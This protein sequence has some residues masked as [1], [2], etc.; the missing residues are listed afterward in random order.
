MTETEIIRRLFSEQDIVY[1]D[2][3]CRLLPG[4]E[5]ERVIGV[6]TPV[7]RQMAKELVM[8]GNTEEFLTRLPHRYFEENQLHSFI[9]SQTKNFPACIGQVEA[10]LPFI[11]NWATCDQLSPHCFR[12]HKQTLLPHIVSWLHS[13]KPY[14]IRF[15]MKMLMDYFLDDDFKSEFLQDVAAVHSEHYYVQMMQAWYF[16]TALAKQ[17][18]AAIPYIVQHRLDRWT[19]NKTIRKACESYRISDEK[20]VYL[21]TLQIAIK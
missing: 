18:T 19:H 14:I 12:L 17:W 9:V 16:A 2:F 13:D 5:R 3:N 1:A 8:E 10:F 6:R 20:K 21:K 15:G 11:D 4:I 7:L